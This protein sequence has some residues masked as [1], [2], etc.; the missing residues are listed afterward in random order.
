MGNLEK[1]TLE[2]LRSLL[3]NRASSVSLGTASKDGKL[4]IAPVGSASIKD[5]GMITLF[6]GP[7]NRSYTNLKANGDAV[8]M[9]VN[10]SLSKLIKLFFGVVNESPGYRVYVK[11]KEERDFSEDDFRPFKKRL[12]VFAKSKGWKKIEKSLSKLLVFEIE[13][14]REIKLS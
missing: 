11:L 7:L 6:K 10:Y 12:G 13:E 4:N 3:E 2:K 1:D 14:I 9:V 8:I 5:D